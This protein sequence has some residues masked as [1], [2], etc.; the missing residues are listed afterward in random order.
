NPTGSITQHLRLPGQ[1]ADSTKFNHNGFR[2][3]DPAI[4]R[5]LEVDPIGIVGGLNPYG[6]AGQNP[7]RWVDP[8]GLDLM[9]IT[10]GWNGGINVFG[11]SSVAV[12]S[13]GVY[14]YGT[15]TPLGDSTAAYLASQSANRP[16]SVTIIHTTPT[17]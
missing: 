8:S 4:G 2:D 15:E 17:Q 13:A 14:S 7:T 5:Y 12:T 1:Y 11:H 16:Q 9:V 3:Y 10:G 6:Y